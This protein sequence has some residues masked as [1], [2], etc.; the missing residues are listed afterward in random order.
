M[1]PIVE[2]LSHSKSLKAKIQMNFDA[3]VAPV[4]GVTMEGLSDRLMQKA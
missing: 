1:S 2:E 3:V 4:F